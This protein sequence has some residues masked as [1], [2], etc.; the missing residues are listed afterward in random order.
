MSAV[1]D[2][3]RYEEAYAGSDF[4]PVQAR[5]RKRKLLEVLGVW[6]PRR[7]LEIGC[8]SDALFNHYP[9]FDRFCV[10]EPGASFAQQ[11]QAHAAGDTQ[12]QIVRA[13]MEDAV[14]ALIGERFDAI[15]LSGLLH[16]VPHCEPLLASVARLCDADTRIHVNVPNARSLHRLLAREMGLIDALQAISKRQQ[17]LQQQRTFDLDSLARLC[18]SAGFEVF[19]R[20]S[21]FVKPF[22]HEQMGQLQR[23]GLLDERMLTGL[24]GLERE[25]PGLGSEIFVHLR[26]AQRRPTP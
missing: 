18:E 6:Q 17:A 23:S 8:G 7:L 19:E 3:A 16:E 15:L 5:M 11:A 21:Y 12:V 25:L 13:F 24:Y 22:T 1:R 2:I 10:V 4:E 20:G 26:L 14:P 9:D